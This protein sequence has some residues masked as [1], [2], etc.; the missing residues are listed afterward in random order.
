MANA[1]LLWKLRNL[2]SLSPTS[3][4]STNIGMLIIG[5]VDGG[6]PGWPHPYQLL[7]LVQLPRE[8]YFVEGDG[9]CGTAI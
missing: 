2:S 3:F 7:S 6:T 5:L 9:H 1:V 8:A 4:I